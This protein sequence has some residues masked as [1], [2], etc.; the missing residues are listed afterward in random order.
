MNCTSIDMERQKYLILIGDNVSFPRI[1]SI[2]FAVNQTCHQKVFY[3]IHQSEVTFYVG[4]YN[5]HSLRL[6]AR[7]DGAIINALR[8]KG[9]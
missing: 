9:N 6:C 8:K 4:Y 2:K 5:P 3:S 7:L 1:T